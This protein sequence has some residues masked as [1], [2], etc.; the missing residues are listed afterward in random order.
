MIWPIAEI[1]NKEVCKYL[2]FFLLW[3][4]L[5]RIF[6]ALKQEIFV[7][8]PFVETVYNVAKK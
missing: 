6:H 7:N 4:L 1:K 8:L 2:G 5:D 3:L